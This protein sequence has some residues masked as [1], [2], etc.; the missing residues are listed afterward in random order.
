MTIEIVDLPSGT[1][2]S[3]W[4]MDHLS[5]NFPFKASIQFGDFPASHGADDHDY[6]WVPSYEMLTFHRFFVGFPWF[7]PRSTPW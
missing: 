1:Q 3:Q 6:Q 7:S 5:V 2:T 4:K